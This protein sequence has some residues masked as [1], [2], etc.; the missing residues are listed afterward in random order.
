VQEN[1]TWDIGLS[2]RHRYDLTTYD[3]TALYKCIIIIIIIINRKAA[4]HVYTT[5]E[6]WDRR[7]NQFNGRAAIKLGFATHSSLSQAAR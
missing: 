4:L 7:F 6:K 3:L 1:S 2:P 5:G